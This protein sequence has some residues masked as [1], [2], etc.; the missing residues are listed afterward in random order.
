MKLEGKIN[1]NLRRQARMARHSRIPMTVIRIGDASPIGSRRELLARGA[2]VVSVSTSGT[3]LPECDQDQNCTSTS[4]PCRSNFKFID[5][6]RMW[7]AGHLENKILKAD[8]KATLDVRRSR[9]PRQ[10]ADPKPLP[11]CSPPRCEPHRR[12]RTRDSARR[13]SGARTR[14][15]CPHSRGASPRRWPHRRQHRTRFP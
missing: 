8:P 2:H 11:S 4:E 7:R 15:V 5:Y 9:R 14:Q 6:S 12:A 3:S 13:S 10:L 1:K